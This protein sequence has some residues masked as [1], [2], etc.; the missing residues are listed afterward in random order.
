MTIALPID[1]VLPALRAALAAHNAAVVVSPPGSGKTTRVPPAL[2]A[3]VGARVVV[4]EPRRVA[5]R[6]AAR[7]M[8]Q[9][10]GQ[11]VGR[12]VGY[13][14]RFDRCAGP[15]TVILVVTEG[16]FLR[17]LQEDPFLDGISAVVF[18]EFHER[19]LQS[20][21]A[22]AMTRKVQREVREDLRVVV[23]SATLAA[24]PVA[25]YLGGCPVIEGGGR[26]FSVDVSHQASRSDRDATFGVAEAVSGVLARTDGDVLVF[27]PGGREIRQV[28][29]ALPALDGVV[30]LPLHGGLPAAEQ[31]AALERSSRRKIVLATNVAETSVTVDGVTAVVDMGLARIPRRDPRTG[32]TRLATRKISLASANQRAG[33]AGRQG[34]GQCLR[35][36]TEAEERALAAFDEPEILR[37]DLDSMLLQLMSWGEADPRSFAWFEPP[38]AA[39][40]DAAL[41][42]LRWLGAIADRGV[43]ELGAQMARLPLE[44]RLAAMV[45]EAAKRGAAHEGATLAALLSDRDPFDRPRSGGRGLDLLERVGLLDAFE[46]GR[47]P[48]GA[49]RKGQAQATLRARR[50]IEDAVAGLGVKGEGTP[51]E[52]AIS[53]AVLAGFPDRVAKVRESDERGVR[54]TM[55]GGR[56]V[57]VGLEDAANI[58]ELFVCLAID[59][60]QVGERSHARADLVVGVEPAW[61]PTVAVEDSQRVRF[62]AQRGRV[63][64]ERVR[65]Y[66]GD[67]VLSA[68]E[69]AVDEEAS[70]AAL[71]SAVAADEPSRIF[72]LDD[73][74]VA[75][76]VGRIRCAASWVPSLE[77]PDLSDAGLRALL[78]RLCSGCRSLRDLRDPRRLLDVVTGLL[79][80]PQRR[81]L[82]ELAPERIEVPSGSQRSVRYE[83]GRPPVLAVRIQEMFGA[84]TTPTVAG[85]R[86]P[87][88]LHLLAPNG[89]PQQV[90]DD[91]ENFW[92]VTYLEV[93]K[94]LRRRYPK[95]AWPDDPAH[96][97]PER[98]PQRRPRR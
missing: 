73:A 54:A 96:A 50:Q 27:L 52:E 5:A 1:D 58:G 13:H 91:L 97:V 10:C 98:R 57:S 85:G 12:S 41:S 61:L 53:R 15:T 7:R 45:L 67:L 88:V 4:L 95:H 34:P 94:E 68:V 26:P 81:R 14:V 65:V 66:G 6:A 19:S 56:G 43:T 64:A 31:D 28:A 8:A 18:D 86:V 32:L 49:L 16:I 29:A 40:V 63:V 55:V 17:M 82:D 11:P 84:A 36:W 30:V 78:P 3:Q 44:P 24:E 39:A 71:A 20:D 92:K 42:L 23:M 9:E 87:V 75:T 2:L 51:R 48:H 72:P 80:W 47:A 69:T 76:L 35:L 93:R 25:A 37:V 21:L 62:D 38:P 90:T 46:R 79:S 77:L 70:A 33:R 60:G 74:A 59:A 83:F 89:R 22:L